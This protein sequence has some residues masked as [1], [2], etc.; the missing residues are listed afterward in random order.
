MIPIIFALKVAVC[1]FGLIICLVY[2]MSTLLVVVREKKL[3][4]FMSLRLGGGAVLVTM[5]VCMIRY[6]F[7]S[8]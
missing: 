7:F 8:I 5:L 1:I 6:F 3:Y 2:F 4:G